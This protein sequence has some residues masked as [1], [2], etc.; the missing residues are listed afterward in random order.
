MA[1]WIEVTCCECG[2]HFYVGWNPGEPSSNIIPDNCSECVE[3]IRQA[4]Q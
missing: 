3:K 2:S 1:A 4:P